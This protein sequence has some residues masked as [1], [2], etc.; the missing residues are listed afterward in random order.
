M[1][2]RRTIL[3]S[4]VAALTVGAVALLVF[5]V[6]TAPAA[7]NPEGT[8]APLLDEV[9]QGQNAAYTSTFTNSGKT[10]THVE[11]HSPIP[12]GNSAPVYAS[13]PHRMTATELVCN[14]VKLDK[15]QTAR[16][17]I[18]WLAFD[19]EY[20]AYWTTDSGSNSPTKPKKRVDVGP[21]HVEL[22]DAGDASKASSYILSSCDPNP[23]L[24]T[25][26]D[27]NEDNPLASRVCIPA[28]APQSNLLPGLKGT[29]EETNVE[30]PFPQQSE[31]CIAVQSCDHPFT[32]STPIVFTFFLDEDSFV[33]ELD[34]LST[35]SW[36]PHESPITQVFH[37]DV[38]VPSCD[39]EEAEDLDPC[40]ES[41]ESDGY[42]TTTVV[43]RG[44]ENGDWRYG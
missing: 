26:P 23:T 8:L 22:I 11:F 13:C 37:D 18:V 31:I 14:T 19:S 10:Q 29:V 6:G 4:S 3:A 44:T 30:E 40:V 15:G 34:L 35:Y 39:D 24:E 32:F 36:Y 16:V 43:A 33:S 17:T 38:L 12:T 7:K 5:G 41:I 9:T 2:A 20:S 28:F 42:G 25:N 1:R 27:V 21:V